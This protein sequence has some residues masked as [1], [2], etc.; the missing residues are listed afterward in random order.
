MGQR[1]NVTMKHYFAGY[2][3]SVPV[4]YCDSGAGY[5]YVAFDNRRTIQAAHNIAKAWNK[6]EQYEM[7]RKN[8]S[9]NPTEALQTN[10]QE[11]SFY[12]EAVSMVATSAAE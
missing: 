5:V 4:V 2:K 1:K 3:Y 11:S 7:A 12:V 9:R 8:P 10:P 6:H